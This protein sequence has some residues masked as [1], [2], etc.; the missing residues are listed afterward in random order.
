MNLVEL[1]NQSIGELT[2]MAKEFHI[3]GAS[4]MPKQSLIFSLLQ[5]NSEQNGLIY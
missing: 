2:Q 1:K 5:A 4:G 3:E